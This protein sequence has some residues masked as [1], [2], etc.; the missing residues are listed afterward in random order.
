M[1]LG[2]ALGMQ[3]KNPDA[4]QHLRRAVELDPA[5]APARQNLATFYRLTGRETAA[6]EEYRELLRR[7]PDHIGAHNALAAL[8][9]NLGKTEEAAIH[10]A[11]ARRLEAARQGAASG[12]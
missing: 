7:A 12:Q 9:Q 5:F 11:A 2:M 10:F 1:W 3:N 6:V 4:E 8:L